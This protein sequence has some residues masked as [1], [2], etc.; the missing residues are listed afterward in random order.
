M[1]DKASRTVNQN[2][3]TIDTQRSAVPPVNFAGGSDSHL[4]ESSWSLQ[5][6]I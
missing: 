4:G 3:S 1:N 2:E 6:K 5:D